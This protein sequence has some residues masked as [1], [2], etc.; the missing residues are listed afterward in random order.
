MHPRHRRGR[1][2]FLEALQCVSVI[3]HVLNRHFLNSK[4]ITSTHDRHPSLP[5]IGWG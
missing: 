3:D 5:A 2:L 1:V 4:V